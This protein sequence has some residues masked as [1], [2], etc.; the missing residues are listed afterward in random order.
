M[1]DRTPHI[2][3]LGNALVDVVATVEQAVIDR[4]GLTTGGMHLVD[5]QA[6]HDL[7]EEVGP[8]VRQSGGSV[9]NSIAHLADIGLA[10][11][12]LGKVA[13]D[14]LGR[15]FRDEM[16]GLGIAAPL[17]DGTA[18]EAGTGRCVVLVTPDGERTMSTYLGAA[19]TIAPSAVSDAMPESFDML[20]I[21]GY[22]W[23]APH[24]AAVIETAAQRAEAAGARIALSP[25]DPGCVERNGDVMQNFISRH[26]DILI[27]NHHELDALAG[28]NGTEDALD[29][30]LGR[31]PVA[32]VTEH[33]KG[34][35]VADETGRHHIPAVAVPRVIDT[36]GAGD[37]YAS[38]F[39]GGLARGQGAAPAG[40]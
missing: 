39:L 28:T 17:S 13:A 8:G 19:T 40:Q 24:G 15:S 32:A 27:G 23:D 18:D 21:E 12:Y 14:D 6:A 22:L 16:T 26:A 33:D 7:F 25:S 3:G 5:A 38:G 11:T 10:G 9:A 2:V 4:H 30:A 34:S 36:T 29:W 37:A 35:L 20:F 31:V 1:I